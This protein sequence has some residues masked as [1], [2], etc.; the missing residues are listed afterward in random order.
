M[1]CHITI[2]KAARDELYSVALLSL[3]GH[4]LVVVKSAFVSSYYQNSPHATM[5]H[6]EGSNTRN[7]CE[8]DIL[9]SILWK[10]IFVGVHCHDN[11]LLLSFFKTIIKPQINSS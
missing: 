7:M 3:V 5:V 6:T 8:N 9:I 1:A 4:K 10:C 2:N 11:V